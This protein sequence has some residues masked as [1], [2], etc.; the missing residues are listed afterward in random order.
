[1]TGQSDGA[2]TTPARS[3]LITG[4]SSGIGLAA[5]QGLRA[6]GWSVVASCRREEDCQRLRD[7][8]FV[9]PRLDYQDEASIEAGFAAALDALG[10]RID[11]L[12]NNGAFASPGAVEDLPTQA[13]REIFEANVFGW[14]ALTRLAVRQMRAQGAGRIVQCSSI[15]GLIALRYRGAYVATKF[16]I[17]GLTD[18]LRL[19]LRGSGVEVVLIEPGPIRTPFHLNAYP[20]FKKWI[21]PE[22]SAHAEIYREVERRLTTEE[23]AP[24]RFELPPEAVVKKLIHALESPRP[25]LR[26]YVTTPTYIG[27]MARRLL[28]TR[29]LDR[30]LYSMG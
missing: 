18:T 22:G 8:G 16:A 3:V 17:E 9:S 24:N 12:Y 1:M 2:V 6:R 4:C 26:Y 7:L 21:R 13:L 29:W 15:L 19:E 25:R 10:G 11:A 14:H 30:F 28:P 5:A 27:G 23:T 20:H